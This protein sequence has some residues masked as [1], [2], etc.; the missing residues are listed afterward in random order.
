MLISIMPNIQGGH[1]T[2]AIMK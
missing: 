2:S 1:K